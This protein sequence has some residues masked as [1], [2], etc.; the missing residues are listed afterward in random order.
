M[1]NDNFFM[2]FCKSRN[3][4]NSTVKSYKSAILKYESFHERL[5][6]DLIDEA[7][8]D[9][10]RSVPLKNRRIKRRL[11]DFRDFLLG[12]DLSI[13]TVRTYFSRIK[14]FYRHFEVEL[15]ILNTLVWMRNISHPMAI[16]QQRVTSE[17]PVRFPVL[18]S[19]LSS[20]SFQAADVPR[21]KLYLCLLEISS[22]QLMIIIVVVPLMMS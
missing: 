4:K 2:A 8:R 14:T 16:C 3:I 15:P 1:I 10:E 9:E 21:L 20:F 17:E 19:W 18:I 6:D 11:L 22:G 12:S 13:G 7:I 5:M